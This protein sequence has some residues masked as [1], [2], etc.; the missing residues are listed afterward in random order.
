MLRIHF[1]GADLENVRLARRPDVLWEI[2][3]SVCRLQT[4]EEPL[5]FDAWRSTAG[6]LLRR[7]GAARRSALALRSLVPNATYFPDFLTPPS[8]NAV[9]DLGVGVDRVLATPRHRL[10]HEMTLL[11]ADGGR[12]WAGAA[13]ARGDVRA[14]TELGGHLRTYYEQFVAPLWDRVHVATAADLALRTR[15]LV[16]GG[17][18]ALLDS[19]RPMAVWQSPVLSVDY[20]I[21]RDLHLGGRGLLLV[22]SYFCARRPVA[23]ADD[24]LG[25]V[26]VVPVDRTCS[27]STAS[28]RTLSRLLGATRAALLYEA[29]AR[30]ATTSE[31]AGAV[32][33]SLPS[34]SQ[35][36]TALR[37]GGLVVS[38]RDGKS[39]RHTATPLGHRLLTG[40]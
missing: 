16:D 3:C 32:G 36:L 21:D 12:P 35:Q 13:L 15:A 10:R 17:N 25:P 29:A 28:P 19:L 9:D 33:V 24:E 14:L 18:Q 30:E 26:L 11:A 27:W 5:A 4:R 2:V 31:L 20:P 8:Q 7:G 39:V 38:R 1:T 37:D 6:T 40:R 22:P 34:A 23:L